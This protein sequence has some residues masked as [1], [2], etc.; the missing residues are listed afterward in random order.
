MFSLNN[1]SNLFYRHDLILKEKMSVIVFTPCSFLFS[2]LHHLLEFTVL[3]FSLELVSAK[4]F[5]DAICEHKKFRAGV[6][7]VAPASNTPAQIIRS[8]LF[9]G[10]LEYMMNKGMIPK[11]ACLLMKNSMAIESSHKNYHLRR[12]SLKEDL[13][14]MLRYFLENYWR[15]ST[16]THYWLPLSDIQKKTLD[17]LLSGDDITEVAKSLNITPQCVLTRRNN[18]IKKM[19]LRNRI[20]LMC[21]N[22]DMFSD[23]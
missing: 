8:R 4:T 19:G 15:Y 16:F 17:A 23:I 1:K 9:V 7:I 12:D 14:I 6:F 11:A 22:R 3:P 20:G 10:K 18:L 13:N 5:D 2:G 21:M